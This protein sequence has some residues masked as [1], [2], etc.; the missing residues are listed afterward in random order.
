[1]PLKIKVQISL[2]MPKS[3]ILGP[4][5]PIENIF[6]CKKKISLSFYISQ[7]FEK[8]LGHLI[9]RTFAI[10]TPTYLDSI[11]VSLF[12]NMTVETG[13]IQIITKE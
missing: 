4:F 1:M 11:A 8:T 3:Q 2:K 13:E 6:F 12:G 10:F 5:P 7:T 9:L